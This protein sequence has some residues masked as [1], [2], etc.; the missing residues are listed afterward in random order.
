MFNFPKMAHVET[1]QFALVAP[2]EKEDD[3]KDERQVNNTHE[4]PLAFPENNS[5]HE[6][7]KSSW[8]VN[9]GDSGDSKSFI[10]IQDFQTLTNDEIHEE[11]MLC[12]VFFISIN[13]FAFCSGKTKW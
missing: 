4:R 7:V 1:Q 10:S 6:V 9:I 2:E 8:T 11:V 12:S 13:I 3:E 5:N